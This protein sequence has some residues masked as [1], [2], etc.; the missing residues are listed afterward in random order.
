MKKI[1]LIAALGLSLSS[2]ANLTNAWDTLTGAR[3]SP[4]TVYVARNSA[5]IVERSATN[6]LRLCH[7]YPTNVGCSK[8]AETQVVLAVRS[9]RVARTNLVAYM[10]DHPS[11]LGAQGVYDAFTSSIDALKKILANYNTQVAS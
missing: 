10:K 7:Q 4:T 11:A 3:V 6:Y 9:L 5:D 2:C 1:L 8:S